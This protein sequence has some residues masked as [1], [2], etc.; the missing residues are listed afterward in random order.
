MQSGDAELSAQAL[1]Q[2]RVGGERAGSITGCGQADDQRALGILGQWIERRALTGPCDR[3]GEVARRLLTHRDA[4][5][6]LRDAGAMRVAVLV[7]PF[8][9]EAGEKLASAQCEGVVEPFCREVLVE[10]GS[11]D[12]HAGRS[13]QTHALAGR[14][15]RLSGVGP[16]RSAQRPQAVA[17]ARAGAR[18]QHVRPE[19][20]GDVAPR[21]AAG[22]EREPGEQRARAP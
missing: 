20:G 9:V 1:A 4:L 6:Q 14:D 13:L 2:P 12:P 17:L 7:D 10:H 18:V 8:L 15:Q 16:E 11:I 19:A 22:I 5:Q 21:V 3:T